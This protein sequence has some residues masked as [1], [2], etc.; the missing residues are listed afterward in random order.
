[1]ELG[2]EETIETQQREVAFLVKDLRPFW[3]LRTRRCLLIDSL[4][5]YKSGT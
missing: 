4:C 5:Y 1:M 3:L 2:L